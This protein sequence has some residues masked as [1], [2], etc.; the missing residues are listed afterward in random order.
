MMQHRF[1]AASI[2]QIGLDLV[3]LT[4]T[5]TLLRGS[6]YNKCG[7]KTSAA[8]SKQLVTKCGKCL[9]SGI[10]RRIGEVRVKSDGEGK[11]GGILKL[12]QMSDG[13]GG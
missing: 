2:P 6:G 4:E 8:P 7:I 12:K 9:C 11:S 1:G 5:H 13:R 3:T 10:K